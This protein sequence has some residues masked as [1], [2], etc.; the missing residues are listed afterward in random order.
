MWT[1]GSLSAVTWQYMQVL[2]PIAFIGIAMAF[3]LHKRLDGLL[4]GENYA[5]GFRYFNCSNAFADSCGHWFTGRRHYGF[6]W[7]LWLLLG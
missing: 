6:L 5:R 7:G 2:L 1:F 3:F 4:L